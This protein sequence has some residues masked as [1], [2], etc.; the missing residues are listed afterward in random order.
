MMRKLL[1]LL[2]ILLS[3]ITA[4]AQN[5][6]EKP[7]FFDNWSVGVAG[8]VYHPMFYDL[9]YL[10]DCSGIAGGVELRKDI[11][12]AFALGIEADGYYRMERK[13]RKD[14]RTVIGA[15]AH[16]NLMNL[17]AGYQGRPRL[18]ELEAGVMPAW[19]HL[20]RGVNSPYFP[21]EN[22]LAAKFNLDF[23]F[24]LGKTRAWALS[25]KPSV[26]CDITS[27]PPN[28]G[29]VIYHYN[30]LDRK[31]TDLLLFVG[32]RYKFRNH[33]RSRHFNYATPGA[34]LDELQRLNESVN[35]LRFDVEQ[36]DA[37]IESLKLKIKALEEELGKQKDI[38]K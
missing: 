34:D 27:R 23:N 5:Y 25:L 12:P 31:K 33:D 18:F 19:G 38:E 22:Y 13:E 3:A 8:G 15:M 29:N 2:L 14:P 26:V 21:D 7:R 35:Y 20:Y 24:N 1:L 17:F 32:F 10:V 11:T 30:V 37:E 4:E 28:H 6:V 9:K 16:V 36:R